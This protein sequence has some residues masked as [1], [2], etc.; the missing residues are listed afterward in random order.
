MFEKERE[1]YSIKIVDL[2]QDGIL[3][4]IEGNSEQQNYVFIG[5]SNGKF[6]EIGL[7]EDLKDDTYNIE[8]G[9]LD[10]DGFPEIVVSNSGS[11]NLYYK[12]RK[13]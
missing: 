8:I 10:N 11:W 6:N 7:R 5:K 12:T 9:D 1:T 3:D 4:I 2:N 13:E